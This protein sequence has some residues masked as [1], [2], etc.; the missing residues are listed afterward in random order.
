MIFMNKIQICNKLIQLLV[1]ILSNTKYR[2]LDNLTLAWH[3]IWIIQIIYPL[4]HFSVLIFVN[5]FKLII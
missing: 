2:L 1:V 4:I 5:L 3:S